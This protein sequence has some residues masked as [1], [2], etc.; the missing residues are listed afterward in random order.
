LEEIDE[1]AMVCDPEIEDECIMIC[2][3]PFVESVDGGCCD[4]E[5][6]SCEEI[7][8]C[9]ENEKGKIPRWCDECP[10]PDLLNDTLPRWLRIIA[11]LMGAFMEFHVVFIAILPWWAVGIAI[12]LVDLLLD[13]LWWLIFGFFCKPC[14]YVFIWIFNI[15]LLPLHV[16]FWYQRLHLELIGFIMDFWTLFFGGDGCFLRWG[17]DC[18]FAKKLKDRNH[19]TYM[20]LV[21]LT[22]RPNAGIAK[23]SY[24]W[25]N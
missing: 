22:A 24:W 25:D 6:S 13:G 23:Y 2:Q 17:Q 12:I 9:P 4:P 11:Q 8:I 19:V 16:M 5:T 18:W 14:A 21:W 7:C 1:E 15:A 20:D 10:N 3:A